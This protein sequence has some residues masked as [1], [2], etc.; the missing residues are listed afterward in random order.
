MNHLA[1]LCA[2]TGEADRV[3]LLYRAEGK[4]RVVEF[5]AIN[6]PSVVS[7]ILCDYAQVREG[8]LFVSSGGIT[9]LLRQT[10]PAQLGALY[11]AVLIEVPPDALDL[12]HEV[13]ARIRSVY[14]GQEIVS[15]SAALNPP[16]RPG[17]SY[18]QGES[19]VIPLA[20]PLPGHAEL[21]EYGPYDVTVSVDGEP[22]ARLTFYL[23]E[24]ALK[25]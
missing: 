24:P 1:T 10:V 4:E 8:L 12:K 13:S 6:R 11:L 14:G 18:E 3:V 19:A 17:A 21:P 23:R 15:V 2:M 20:L 9:R 16:S 5:E 25:R 22:P 7:A